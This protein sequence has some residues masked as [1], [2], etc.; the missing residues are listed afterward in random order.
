MNTVGS[1]MRQATG[2]TGPHE[3]ERERERERLNERWNRGV[4]CFRACIF[5]L[6][7]VPY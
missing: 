6:Q 2:T 1:K 4:L 7:C 3:R 5:F